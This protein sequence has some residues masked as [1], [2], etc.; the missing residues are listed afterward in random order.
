VVHNSKGT[1]TVTCQG[2]GSLAIDLA[3]HLVAGE[4]NAVL[5]AHADLNCAISALTSVDLLSEGAPVGIVG[6]PGAKDVPVK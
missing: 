3:P 5:L 1:N 4:I 2:N 6:C